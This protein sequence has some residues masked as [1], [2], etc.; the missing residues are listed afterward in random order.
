M[1]KHTPRGTAK[2]S[3]SVITKNRASSVLPEQI[4][5]LP[6][7]IETNLSKENAMYYF[8]TVN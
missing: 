5:N 2:V 1:N 7:L 4:A 6:L 3:F 8:I